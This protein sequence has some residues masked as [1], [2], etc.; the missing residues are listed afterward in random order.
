MSILF[1]NAVPFILPP[2]FC[3]TTLKRLGK[4][5]IGEDHVGKSNTVQEINTNYDNGY[6]V[7]DF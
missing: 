7:G 1:P 4:Y 2:A 6:T 5:A 3:S